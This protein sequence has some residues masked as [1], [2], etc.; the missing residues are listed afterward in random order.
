MG[1]R[2]EDRRALVTGGARGIGEAIVR[3]F[4]T[5]GAEVVIADIRDDEGRALARELGAPATYR[6]LD[7]TDEA[8][9]RSLGDQAVQHPFDVVVNNAGAVVSFEPLHAIDPDLF[10]RIL[11]LNLTSVFLSMRFLIPTMVAAGGGSVINLSSISGVVGHDVAPGYQSAKGGVR[12]L[13]KNGAITYATSGVR[14]NSI[15]PG[16]IATPMVAE[17]PEWATQAFVGGTPMG[18]AGTPEDV[19][20]AA[21]YLASDESTF[22]TG[23]ELTI[24]GGFTAA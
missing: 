14:V 12:V 24:D 22:V 19:A 4:V 15:H 16:I 8:A 2:L 9:W 20:H 11:E 13:T 21:V 17:Q 18:R 5:E 1:G 23:A 10:R 7:V 3:R 6:H